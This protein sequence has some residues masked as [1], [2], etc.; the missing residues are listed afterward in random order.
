MEKCENLFEMALS[1]NYMFLGFDLTEEQK[2]IQAAVREFAEKELTPD[3]SR[4]YEEKHE[5]PWGLYRKACQH[6]FLSLHFPEEFGGQGYG[7]MEHFICLYEAAKIDPPLADTII[8]SA[9]FGVELIIKFGNHEQK[10]KWLPSLSEGEITMSSMFTEPSGGSDL[11]RP[12]ETRATKINNTDWKINGTKTFVTNGEI[13]TVANVLA[14]TNMEAKPPYRGQTL[15][16]VKKGPNVDTTPI[17]GKMGWQM[18]PTSEVTF[19]DVMVTDEDVLGGPENLNKGLYLTLQ[20]LPITRTKIGCYSIAASE[21]ALQT[22]IKYSKEREAFGRKIGGFQGLAH[23]IVDLATE[24][25]L[26]KSLLF[27]TIKVLE[28]AQVDRSLMD[29]A[30]K[31]ASMVKYYGAALSVKACDLAID[32][33]GGYGYL[34]EYNVERWFRWAKKNDIVEGTKEIQKNTIAR[35]LLGKELTKYF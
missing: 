1:F 25:E 20:W 13:F 29:E 4:E 19:R 18:S 10:A 15:F 21:A 30:A 3:K 5:F 23:R 31:L 8:M 26:G 11:T 34:A 28:K 14:Q 22:A 2:L 12:L 32:V 16:L 27:R 35:Q 17:H 7:L 9:H 33:L 24:V 6:G